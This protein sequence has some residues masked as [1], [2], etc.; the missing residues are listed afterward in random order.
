MSEVVWGEHMPANQTEIQ[1][2]W[3]SSPVRV[4]G[5]WWGLVGLV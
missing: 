2:S 3:D 4:M 1:L 5:S